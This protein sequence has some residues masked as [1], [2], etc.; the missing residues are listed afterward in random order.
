MVNKYDHSRGTDACGAFIKLKQILLIPVAEADGMM[1][2]IV[3]IWIG[4]ATETQWRT[5]ALI[6][7]H[8]ERWC[9]NAFRAPLTS[10]YVSVVRFH[11]S[12]LCFAPWIIR[13]ALSNATLLQNNWS[14]LKNTH[15]NVSKYSEYKNRN[16]M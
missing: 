8:V 9:C 7:L 2:V 3:F 16:I 13:N 11:Q 15:K 4:R 5:V 1:R 10:V 14:S 6:T 12:H